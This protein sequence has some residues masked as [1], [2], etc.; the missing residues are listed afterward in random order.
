M[1]NMSSTTQGFRFLGKLPL[2]IQYKIVHFT[3]EPQTIVI[4][5]DFT[6]DKIPRNTTHVPIALQ[7]NHAYRQEA[8]KHFERL[9]FISWKDL[10]GVEATNLEHWP[11]I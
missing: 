5:N 7:I 3:Y 6:I 10:A 4:G 9:Q 2:E 8:L 11:H 1:A